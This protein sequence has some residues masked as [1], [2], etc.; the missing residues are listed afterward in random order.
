MICGQIRKQKEAQSKISDNHELQRLNISGLIFK[1]LETFDFGSM[2]ISSIAP[3]QAG[4]HHPFKAVA[5]R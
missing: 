4:G 2:E 3:L 5:A 1:D